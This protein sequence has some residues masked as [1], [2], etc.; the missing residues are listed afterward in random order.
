MRAAY[1]L[2]PLAF[3]AGVALAEPPAELPPPPVTDEE[4]IEPE[5]RIIKRDDKTI[6]EYRVN[7]Q[8]YMIKVSPKNAPPYYLIDTDGDGTMEAS[9]TEIE[10]NLMIPQW[11]LFRW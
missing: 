9:R 8:L 3:G 5:V 10:P 7:G 11:V 6:E 4:E 2:V 1:L